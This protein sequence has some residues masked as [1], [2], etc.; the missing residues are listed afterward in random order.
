MKSARWQGVFL[1][2][3]AC[4]LTLAQN[5]S[6]SVRGR[7]IDQSGSATA[8]IACTLTNADTTSQY[9]ANTAVNG[10]FTFPNV[11]PGRYLLAVR[12]SGFKALDIKNI[13][14]LASETH[15]LGAL[16][17]FVGDV[18][19]TVAVTAEAATL[20]LASS[21]KAATITGD[22][23]NAIA[24]KGR[25]LFALMA[26][27]P[28][29]VDDGSQARNTTNP[30]NINGFY[31]NGGRADQKNFTVD[32]VTDMDI[33]S[34]STIHF[35]PTL[36]SI[37]ETRVMTSNYQAEFGRNSG[38]VITVIT[39]GG[40][41]DFHG[42]A[43][44]YYRNETLNANSFFN[45][46]TNTPRAP[47]RYRISGGTIGGPVYIPH[48]F[49]SSKT[50]LFFFESEE[51]T[52]MKNN[53]PT[54]LV[55]TPTQLERNGDFSQ[56]RLVNGSLLTITDPSTGSPF[57]GNVIPSSRFNSMGQAILNFYPV[58]NYTDP[59]PSNLYKYNYRSTY[60]GSYPRRNDFIRIDANLTP[61]LQVY[62]RYT[63]DKDEQVVPYSQW[64]S[65]AINYLL[66]PITFGQPG[67]GHVVH[68]TKT[69]GSS[70]VNEFIFGKSYNHLYFDVNDPSAVARSKMGNP[71]LWYAKDNIPAI[72]QLYIP[73]VSFGSQPAN[74]I[75]SSMY[76]SIPYQ[77]YNNIWD[78]T[79][80][81]NKVWHSHNF[82]VGFYIEHSEKYF[83]GF[84]LQPRGSFNFAQD[85]NNPY[86]TNDGFAN[87]LLGYFD[88]YSESTSLVP[89]DWWFWD[90][91]W[92]AQ[93]NWKVSK[94]LTLDIGIRM[95]H[96][97]ATTDNNLTMASFSPLLFQAGQAPTM[98]VPAI[99]AQGQRVAKNPLTGA[100]AGAALIGLF[101]PGTGNT[102]NGEQRCGQNGA[103]G[104]CFNYPALGYGPRL[105]F[106]YDVF[107]NGKTAIR[108][109]F[110]MFKDRTE[111]NPMYSLNGNPPVAYTPTAY[112]GSLSN[113]AQT[114][115]VLGPSNQTAVYGQNRMAGTMSYSVS[116]QQQ[117]LQSVLEASYVGSLSR[118]LFD[119]VNVNSIP[120]F[121]HFNPANQ[122]PTNPGKP[123]PDNF[124][125][126]YPGWGT[127]NVVQ[128]GASSNYNALQISVTRRFTRGLQFGVSY[129]HS[130]VLGVANGYSSAIS[131][132]FPARQRNYG[133]LSFDRPNV[134][135][136]N[137]VYE[138][139]KVGDR[140]SF[141]PAR[142]V[143]DNWVLSG[144]TTFQTGAPFTPGLST[145]A[146]T[147]FTG[148]SEGARV[149]V[150]CNPNLA[151]SSRTF[152]Q[153]FNAA[154]FAPPAMNTFGNAGVNILYGP[155]I[156]NW[157]L[158][159]SKRIPLASESRFIQFR[160]ETFNTF[161]H[162][163]FSGLDT[164]AQFNATGQQI[165]PTFGSF[166]AARSP[167]IVQLSGRLVF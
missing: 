119:E 61:S 158:S 153:N 71:P 100:Y 121:A 19:E 75:T 49:N 127:I 6:S 39:K 103:P 92:Y 145:V 33:G 8:G 28:G 46:R 12:A 47:Y 58:P 123:L 50:K 68:I 104:G 38:G 126:P 117:F 113:Y 60:S 30:T 155:G 111:D 57:P 5:T 80:N 90:A 23:M 13:Y 105:G 156:N 91:E 52:G 67:K 11:T 108:G 143:L 48:K 59:T 164:T 21:E 118:H 151:K 102:A 128:G 65:G 101:V 122:D 133:P 82:K 163:Q 161:N 98:Y 76:A 166:T 159:A 35:E 150:T 77:N 74:T 160:V 72:P 146:G 22:Q 25:D 18:K 54:D 139:P 93:D 51:F 110:G 137:Y 95:Y 112:Y 44:D 55:T 167:R 10:D 125:R 99:N 63:H 1:L 53:F 36:D 69:F 66:T 141:R 162:T 86:N 4:S 7:L 124:L 20:Q 138:L 134:F 107:G 81:L 147:D 15:D 9:R 85:V 140:T 70:L 64:E 88:S 17:L 89:G 109:G 16:T 37:A 45:N 94:R 136:L 78:F 130:K 97:P 132:Y 120:M 73:N 26:T 135:V 152:A 165:N 115:G 144:I 114:G 41:Q 27:V 157:D 83:V 34:N 131:Y 116:V 14:V 142:W 43:Y 31:V 106:A 2:F 149:N 84:T 148:S 42:T 79:D 40:T 56:S 3:V 87:A 32:G 129:T 24:I 96:Q 154:C 62:Y 29:V